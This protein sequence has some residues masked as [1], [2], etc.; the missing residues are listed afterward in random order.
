MSDVSCDGLLD[1]AE[2][3]LAMYL[4]D[5]VVVKGQELPAALPDFLHP[6]KYRNP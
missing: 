5:L 3:C 4:I 6:Q 2:F 1:K